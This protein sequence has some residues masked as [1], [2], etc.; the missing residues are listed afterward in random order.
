M[1][2]AF[3]RLL[4]LVASLLFHVS[5]AQGQADLTRA[6]RRV[7]RQLPPLPQALLLSPGAP[8]LSHARPGDKAA[9]LTRRPTPVRSVQQP[10]TSARG[11]STQGVTA[12]SVTEAWVALYDGPS[13]NVASNL[14]VDAAGNTYV[15]GY[16]TTAI[17]TG[18]GNDYVTIKYSPSGQQLWSVL[19]NSGPGN[20]DDRATD[21]AVDAT[22]N[23]YVTGYATRGNS[24]N[25][26]GTTV[27]Y[28]ATGQ[29]LWTASYSGG[30]VGAS[31]ALDATGNVYVGSGANNLVKYAASTGQQ[32]WLLS[33]FGSVKDLAVDAAGNAYVTG[34]AT[35]NGTG[36]DYSTVKFS[37]AGQQ[38]WSALY[39]SGPGNSD[40][41][42]TEIAVDAVGNVYVTGRSELVGQLSD[43]ATL[44][45]SASG[46]E[47]WS[48]RF[49]GSSTSLDVPTALAV[50]ADGNVV[51]TGTSFNNFLSSYDYGTVKYSA[52][53]QQ[54]WQA[55]YNGNGGISVDEAYA[56]AVDAAGDVYVTGYS[57]LTQSISEYATLKYNGA[58]GQQVW[59]TRYAGTGPLPTSEV[60]VAVVVGPTGSVYVTGASSN[61]IIITTNSVLATIKYEQNNVLQVWEARFTPPASSSNEVAISQAADAAGNVYVTGYAYN[62][63]N[64][65]YATVKYAASGQQLWEA[66]YNGRGNGDEIPEALALDSAG[67]VYVT[68]TAYDSISGF[69]YATV[70]YSPTGQQIWEARYNSNG[71]EAATALAIDAAGNVVVTGTAIAA[72]FRDYDYV[73]LKYAA[74]TGQPVWEA[75]YAG[76]GNSNEV[77]SA[78][79]LDSAGNVYVTG[80]ATNATPNDYDYATLKYAAASGRQLWE[81]RYTGT[82]SGNSNEVPT[83][84]VVDDAGNVI[85]TGAATNGRSNYDYVTIKYLGENGAAVVFS[86]YNGTANSDDIPTG[87]ALDATGD[88]VVTGF[89][90][91]TGGTYDYA[92]V[93]YDYI[94]PYYGGR[95]VW[96][97]RYNGPDN[98]YDQAAA[99]AIDPAG[100]VYVTGSSFNRDGTDDYTTLK[101]S[102][103]SGQQL[104]EARYDGP[105]N[106]YDEAAALSLDGA[107]N[108]C[109]TGFSFGASTGYDF[110]T[111]KYGQ[112]TGVGP[113]ALVGVAPAATLSAPLAVAGPTR[114]LHE[115][116]VYPNPASGPTTVS[117]R[118]VLDGSAQV[119]VYNQLGQQVATLYEGKVR[120]GQHYELPLHSEK[121][122]AGLYTCSLLVN[123]QRETV[124]VVVSH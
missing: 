108:V 20:T 81:T 72:N 86:S 13:I 29:Q 102:G 73:T 64:Y 89:S 25:S 84:M 40:D 7:E 59:Q 57:G 104:W 43:Y 48:S 76:I 34:T 24:N 26:V 111:L 93:K 55:L 41:Q 74:A 60:A 61:N 10:A 78:V 75:R 46:Q 14:V 18:R 97:T 44:K 107:G 94:A 33:L 52:S 91:G 9:L 35:G 79:A 98:S 110:A 50:D 82:G 118:P 71:D 90:F 37:P 68:G 63:R 80:A 112:N 42:A 31:L 4:P 3:T 103:T 58:S 105:G 11:T 121:L 109:I 88:A 101:Y 124:R 66:R 47:L 30:G 19:F 21:L 117:F 96:A 115:L 83:A 36:N 95:Q 1:K 5:T 116:A 87:I 56:L 2:Q 53:G 17:T 28:S 38:Q 32:L 45:Y 39:N 99:L 67:N 77:V 8:S 54:V 51:V 12:G 62:G 119:S 106:S 122:S 15:T 120:Q 70:K 49:S 100:N 22:G 69:D 6:S 27:K 16:S 85:V 123:G 92:T 23:V 113:V 65:D 114:Q